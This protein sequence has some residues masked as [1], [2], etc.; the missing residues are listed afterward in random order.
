MTLPRKYIRIAD[1]FDL[2]FLNMFMPYFVI[3][4]LDADD[5]TGAVAQTLAGTLLLWV[6][7]VMQD[8]GYITGTCVP[9][10]S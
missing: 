8:T 4:R 7:L 2:A 6:Y 3:M 9:P 5:I 1:T 10:N